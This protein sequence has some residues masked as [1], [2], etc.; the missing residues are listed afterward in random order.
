[1]TLAPCARLAPQNEPK[2]W[3]FAGVAPS[4]L[5]GVLPPSPLVG[6]GWGE[7]LHKRCAHFPLSPALSRKGRG[8]ENHLRYVPNQAKL[9]SSAL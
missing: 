8:S 9:A 4:P 1:M 6:E 2:A 5:V 3:R 7:G